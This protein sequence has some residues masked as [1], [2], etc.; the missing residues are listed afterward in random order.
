MRYW[1]PVGAV[2]LILS[3]YWFTL[4]PTVTLEDSGSFIATAYCLGVAHPPGYPLWCL[5][6]HGFTHLPLG[7]VAWRVN[8]F[9]TV[10]AAAAALLLFLIAY[11]LTRSRTAAWTAALTFAFSRVFWSQAV[12]AEVYTLNALLFGGLIYCA[13][14]WRNNGRTGW[15]YALAL[16]AGLGLTNHPIFALIAPVPC[17]WAMTVRWRMLLQTRTILVCLTLFIAALSIYAYIPWRARANPPVNWGNPTTWRDTAQHALRRAYYT[18]PE[19]DRY[20]G[21]PKD[22]WR[23]M[24]AAV[25]ESGTALT[26]PVTVLALFGCAV[27]TRR[28]RDMVGMTLAV[29]IVNVVALNLLLRGTAT[30]DEFFTRRVF[31]IPTQMMLALWLAMAVKRLTVLTRGNYYLNFA[32]RQFGADARRAGH[33]CISILQ[34]PRNKADAPKLRDRLL[35]RTSAFLHFV[36]ITH[37]IKTENGAKNNLHTVFIGK[38][39]LNADVRA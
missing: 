21:T 6:A 4:A 36:F 26:W 28:R 25:R 13:M 7:T 19:R 18:E 15:L 2:L 10:C 11:R 5:L 32:S 37:W 12:I 3:V 24:A 39:H 33:R 31:Y 1:P 16:N 35:R 34:A 23:H 22:T 27:L 30:P 9:S 14:R 38:K 8:L 29:M 17:I 20:A